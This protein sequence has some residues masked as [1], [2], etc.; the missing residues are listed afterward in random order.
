MRKIA[1]VNQKGGVGK[2]SISFHLCCALV[3]QGLR[4]LAI[5]LDPQGN[6][7]LAFR[8]RSCHARE[9]LMGEGDPK[10][11]VDEAELCGKRISVVTAN[12]NLPREL[13][14][15]G[16][17]P[18]GRLKRALRDAGNRWDAVVLDTPVWFGIHTVNALVAADAAIIPI[19]PSMF[20]LAGLRE[21]MSFTEMIKNEELNPDLYIAGIVINMY[22]QFG[23]SLAV[24]T[25]R[26]EEELRMAYPKLTFATKIPRSVTVEEALQHGKPVWQYAPGSRVAS[27]YTSFVDETM[28]RIGILSGGTN[29]GQ[30]ASAA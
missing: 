30:S 3:E 18:Y 21:V 10:L 16:I 14:I 11:V 28:P 26:C 8:L 25:R 9:L 7:S 24:T 1:V 6:L 27:A 12:R 13:G 20:S 19:Q 17:Q 5:D 22:E 4:V 2:T 15:K 29:D 23:R